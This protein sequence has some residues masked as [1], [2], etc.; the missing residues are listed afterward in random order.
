V[1]LVV[2]VVTPLP[3]IAVHV[4]QTEAVRRVTTYLART[5]QIGTLMR[6]TIRVIPVEVGLP[7]G[8]GV[9][10]VEDLIRRSPSATGIL[11]F[12]LAQQAVHPS[13]LLFL[14]QRRQFLAE[15]H[16]IF[17]RHALNRE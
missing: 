6:P 11:P 7:G 17:P 16:R 5:F 2:P 12:R 14:G 8:E 4:V 15:G 10:E 9:A 13:L 1:I 3:D